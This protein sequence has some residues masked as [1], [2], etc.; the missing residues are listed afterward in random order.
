M[1]TRTRAAALMLVLSGLAGAY[2]FRVHAHGRA[3]AQRVARAVR[4]AVKAQPPPP[5]VVKVEDLPQV[6]MRK[7]TPEELTPALIRKSNELLWKFDSSP[8]GSEIVL[9]AEGKS[10]IAR[11]EEHFHEVGGP[12][13]PWGFHKGITLYAAE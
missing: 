1:S 4:T 12:V 10:F 13:R 5:P 9:E 3:A 2:F 8:V 6:V 11:F 7:L